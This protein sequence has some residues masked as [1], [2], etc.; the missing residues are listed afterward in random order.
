MRSTFAYS[1]PEFPKSSPSA[2][3]PVH[4]FSAGD[5]DNGARLALTGL[6]RDTKEVWLPLLVFNI[7]L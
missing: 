7:E 5:H 4:L 1:G 6:V 2:D 3:V